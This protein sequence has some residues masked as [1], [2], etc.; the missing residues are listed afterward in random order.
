MIYQSASV[1]INQH[2]SASIN[3][4]GFRENLK[5]G[6]C[7]YNSVLW[8]RELLFEL[9][10]DPWKQMGQLRH[11]PGPLLPSGLAIASTIGDSRRNVAWPLFIIP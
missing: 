6:I 11:V 5:S 8:H 10:I 9:M 2:Q 4:N 3:L 7:I 1:S